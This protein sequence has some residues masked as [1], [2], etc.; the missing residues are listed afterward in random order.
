[1]KYHYIIQNRYI[2]ISENEEYVLCYKSFTKI[3]NLKTHNIKLFSSVSTANQ[4][5]ENSNYRSKYKI[6]QIEV[7][8]AEIS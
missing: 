2:I 1:M 4:Y 6:K 8:Y 7:T 3:D 5:M